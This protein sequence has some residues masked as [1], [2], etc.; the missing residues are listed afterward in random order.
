VDVASPADTQ[1]PPG[2]SHASD[3]LLIDNPPA[4]LSRCS[5]SPNHLCDSQRGER[6]DHLEGSVDQRL[7]AHQDALL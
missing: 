4:A 1:T 2:L 6:S 7:P 3:C 5:R